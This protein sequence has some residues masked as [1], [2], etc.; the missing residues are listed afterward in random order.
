MD[1]I[2]I[3]TLSDPITNE[4]R[5]IG[6]TKNSLEDRLRGHLKGKGKTY[7]VHW[8]NSL[9]KKGLVPNIELIEEVDKSVGS[10]TEIYWILMFRFWGFNLT[11]LTDGGE[12]S[13]TKNIVRSEEWRKNIRIGKLNSDFKYSEESKLKMSESAKKRGVNSKGSQLSKHNLTDEDV[14][15]IKELIRN[16]GGKTLKKIS[17]ELSLPHDWVISLN[18]NRIWKHVK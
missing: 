18:L 11:N 15:K 1:T 8:I 7:R 6:Q 3:Y 10:Q 5:Y 13:T 12:T 9:K 16:R 2:K 17:E 4:V 14:S